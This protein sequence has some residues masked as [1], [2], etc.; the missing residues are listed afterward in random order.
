MMEF[1]AFHLLKAKEDQG[2]YME[3]YNIR[4]RI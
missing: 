1:N 4:I 2:I 3:I